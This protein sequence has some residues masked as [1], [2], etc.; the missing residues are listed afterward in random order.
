MVALARGQQTTPSYANKG[1]TK[2][3]ITYS[4]LRGFPQYP[5]FI[6]R[7]ILSLC[8]R[9]PH[10]K[11]SDMLPGSEKAIE[12]SPINNRWVCNSWD[13]YEYLLLKLVGKSKKIVEAIYSIFEVDVWM[14]LFFLSREWKFMEIMTYKSP[15]RKVPY[16]WKDRIGLT[17]WNVTVAFAT[18]VPGPRWDL[19]TRRSCHEAWVLPNRSKLYLSFSKYLLR[20]W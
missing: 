12:V 19:H 1:N 3:V 7:S 11:S 20:K 8:G 17:A 10:R 2:C 18:L 6:A 15:M 9:P 13:S 5:F 14:I 16:W 4:Q